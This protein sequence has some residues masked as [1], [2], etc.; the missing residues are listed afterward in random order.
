MLGVPPFFFKGHRQEYAG[1]VLIEKKCITNKNKIKQPHKG[2]N[3]KTNAARN[4]NLTI[5]ISNSSSN[6]TLH[7]TDSNASAV[8]LARVVGFP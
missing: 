4:T 7:G 3:N 8:K 6:V 5:L 2:G 1:H